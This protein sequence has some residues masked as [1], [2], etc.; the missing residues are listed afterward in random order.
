MEHL[1]D[2]QAEAAE[3]RGRA[4]LENRTPRRPGD[5][6]HPP[7]LPL[8]VQTA[9]KVDALTKKPRR[10]TSSA[11]TNWVSGGKRPANIDGLDEGRW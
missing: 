8:P 6:H 10:K 2:A 5:K 1:T 7:R 3:A 4:A 11:I 9:Q